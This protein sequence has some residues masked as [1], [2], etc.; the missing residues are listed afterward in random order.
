MEFDYIIVGAGSAGCVLARRLAEAGTASVLLLEAGGSDSWPSLRV[1]IGYGRSFYNP[2]VNWMYRTEPDPMLDDRRG[3]WPRGRVLGGSSTIN[4]MV[5]V[6]G[7]PGDFDDWRDAGNPGWGWQDV[8]PYFRQLETFS[9]GDDPARGRSGPLHVA[10]VS[11]ECHPLCTNFLRAC[12]EAGFPRTG[13]INGGQPEGVGYYQITT[14]RGLRESAARA[15]LHPIARHGNLRIER[16]ARV[17]RVTIAGMRAVGVTF[18]QGREDHQVTARR[19][20]LLAAGAINTPQLLQLSGVGPAALLRQ[21]GIPVAL[22]LPAVGRHLQDHLC[23]DHLFRTSVSTL[24]QALGRASGQVL[25]ALRYGLWRRGPLALSVNQAGGFV[26]SQRD[27][28]R[29]DMQLYFSP[30][31]YTRGTPGRRALMRPDPFP[32]VLLSAQPCRPRSR[33]CIDI[34]SP[35]PLASPRIAANALSHSDDQDALLRAQHLLR[36]I[37]AA[38]A[39][40]EIIVEDL[41][42]GP[43]CS[44]DA[45]LIADMRARASTVFHPVGTCRMGADPATSAVDPALRVHGIAGLRVVDASVFPSVTSGNT[46][47][48]VMMVAEKAASLILATRATAA[49]P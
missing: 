5:Y 21:Y 10:D 11:A 14:H 32:G 41:H 38:P 45:A 30:L 17:L 26:R 6:R 23:I 25:A 3:Y 34:Q 9:G 47:A 24:N 4:A 40:R 36:R 49:M 20:V 43:H 46:N 22:D 15:F 33:G 37:A 16:H 13:D 1:P 18:R 2:R 28:P 48:P 19:E 35:D 27:Q 39:M 44:G 8:L 29:P 42:P 12:E 31:S 7:L